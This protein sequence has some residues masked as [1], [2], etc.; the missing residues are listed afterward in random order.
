MKKNQLW[1]KG[2]R[3]ARGNL[4]QGEHIV[5][6]IVYAIRIASKQRKQ[7]VVLAILNSHGPSVSATSHVNI[8]KFIGFVL[9][10]LFIF[11]VFIYIQLFS[12]PLS[13]PYGMCHV[14]LY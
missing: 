14:C 3:H 6:L 1:W 10:Y 11:L 5:K 9:M 12:H 2:R 4:R 8:S 13:D 7:Y